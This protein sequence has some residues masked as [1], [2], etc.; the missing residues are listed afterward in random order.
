MQDF[1]LTAMSTDELD[2]LISDATRERQIRREPEEGLTTVDGLRGQDVSDPDH[3]A[4]TT[5]TPHQVRDYATEGLEPGAR[6]VGNRVIDAD[7]A[8][9]TDI[10]KAARRI[11]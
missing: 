7:E 6:V 4:I 2:R 10:E 11:V 3:G 1:N 9:E 5:P 8:A